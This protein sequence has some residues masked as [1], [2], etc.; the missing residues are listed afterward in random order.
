MPDPVAAAA[1]AEMAGAAGITVHLREDRRHIQ[2]RD[3]TLLSETVQTKLNLEMSI[4]PTVVAF[5]LETQPQCACLVPEKRE[6]L[7]TEGGLDVRGNLE[8]VRRVTARLQDAGTIV[9]LFIDPDIDQV[10]AAAECGATFIEL[11]TGCF[12]DAVSEGGQLEEL[13]KLIYAAEAAFNH[14]LR[15]NAGHGLNYHNVQYMHEIPRVEELNIGHAIIARAV[16]VGLDRAVRDM[17]AL[18]EA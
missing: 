6:E 18:L 16:L 12:A 3:V 8:E 4:A 10:S 17:A 7:T 14:G 11:H 15:V 5:A 13:G 9:S 2:E 1:I